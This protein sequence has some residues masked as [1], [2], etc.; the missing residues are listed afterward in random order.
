MGQSLFDKIWARH[1]VSSMGDGEHALYID[2]HVLDELHSPQAF[3]ALSSQGLPVRRPKATI[4]V[5][6][7]VVPTDAADLQHVDAGSSL[8]IR[9]LEDN[10]SQF[11]IPYLSRSDPRRGIVHLVAVESGFVLPGQTVVS[12]DSHASTLGAIGALAFGVGASEVQQVL[13]TQTLIRRRPRIMRIELTGALPKHVSAKDLALRL[14]AQLTARGA[15]GHVVEFC[16]ECV[17]SMDMAGRFTLCNMAI[18]FGAISSLVAPDE[19]TFS[20]VE[21]QARG[22]F[23][24]NF[25][26]ARA[27]WLNLH[28]GAGA[29]FD[30]SVSINASTTAPMITYGTN[31]DTAIAIDDPVP[32]P[33]SSAFPLQAARALEYMG[34]V[35]GTSLLGQ[36]IDA[37]FIGSC[38]NGRI[39]D[40]REAAAIVRNRRISAQVRG[41]VVPGSGSVKMQ[42]EAEGLDR[43][44]R[45]AGFEWREPGC[46]MC[47]GMNRDRLAPGQRCLST[48]NRNFEGR[49]GRDARTHLVSPAM[50]AAGAL[51]G[52]VVDVR[53]PAS[54]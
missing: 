3:A 11:G 54:P 35:P 31:P 45:E 18:E 26:A 15:L 12:G 34:L 2:R 21:Q 19:T 24:A 36:A 20:Y 38:A 42:A 46:S 16:G 52:R 23:G 22:A 53:R 4:A 41:L 17:L 10:V 5:A 37:V 51:A 13:A 44:F 27:D 39:E 9:T 6:D 32:S 7:H 50:A 33:D 14:V 1:V 40:L 30:R 25:Q 48:S 8:L 43:V 28:S 49:Q 47:L 29:V